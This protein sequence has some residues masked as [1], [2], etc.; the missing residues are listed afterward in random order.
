M[1][2][3]QLPSIC[4]SCQSLISARQMSRTMA[5]S[6]ISSEDLPEIGLAHIR[7][8]LPSIFLAITLIELLPSLNAASVL[9]LFFFCLGVSTSSLVALDPNQDE[10]KSGFS[11][12]L[13]TR[14]RSSE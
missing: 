11:C 6:F 8:G 2:N 7:M 9:S 3:L 10:A 14:I 12:V 13:K 4:M 5:S 1:S